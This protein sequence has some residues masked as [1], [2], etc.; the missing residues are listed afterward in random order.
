MQAEGFFIRFMKLWKNYKEK[1]K[2]SWGRRGRERS[3]RAPSGAAQK[4]NKRTLF[5]FVFHFGYSKIQCVNS[6][7]RSCARK[8]RLENYLQITV[9]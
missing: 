3:C 5:V 4:S 1:K 2:L 8:Y 7:F 9:F 6:E